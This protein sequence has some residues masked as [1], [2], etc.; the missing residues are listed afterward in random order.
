MGAAVN[1]IYSGVPTAFAPPLLAPRSQRYQTSAPLAAM[2]DAVTLPY[3][4]HSSVGSLSGLVRSLAPRASMH[5]STAV[6]GLPM[7]DEEED[8]RRDGWLAPLLPLQRPPSVCRAFHQQISWLGHAGRGRAIAP[9][10]PQLLPCRSEGGALYVRPQ[11]FALPLSFPQFFS[12]SVGVH[13][14][15]R[16]APNEFV[17]RALRPELAVAPPHRMRAPTSEVLSAP[18]A[19]GLQCTPAIMPVLRRVIADWNT[20]RRAAER[21][22]NAEGWAQRDELAELSEHLASLREAYGED[23]GEGDATSGWS[24]GY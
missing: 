18:I 21:A 8:I 3:R 1:S 24:S 23:E 9:L 22:G 5:I 19:A 6:L 2:L 20:D 12:S 10:I 4:A 7:P 16:G 15:V 14:E 13:G 17:G 11:P